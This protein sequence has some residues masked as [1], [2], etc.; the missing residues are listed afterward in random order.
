MNVWSGGN[1]GIPLI[2]DMLAVR[3]LPWKKIPGAL[4]D[5]PQPINFSLTSRGGVVSINVLRDGAIRTNEGQSGTEA[6]L[7][8]L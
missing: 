6:Q 8:L 5:M 1:E 3:L 2:W 4:Q 7:D